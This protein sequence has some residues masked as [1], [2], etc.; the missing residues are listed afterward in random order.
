MSRTQISILIISLFTI[1]NQSAQENR[2]KTSFLFGK[3]I[4]TGSAININ[5][6]IS[7]T[8]SI[9]YGFD[10]GTDKRVDIQKTGFT[11]S[12]SSV[13]FSLKAAEGNYRVKVIYDAMTFKEEEVFIKAESRRLMLQSTISTDQSKR[14]MSFMVNLRSPKLVDNKTIILKERELTHLNWDEKLTLEFFGGVPV[15]SISIQSVEKIPTLF[16]AGDSTVT[17]QDLE[18][19]ASWGQFVTAYLDDRIVVANYAYSGASLSS[20]KAS[21]RL[22]KIASLM[23]NGDYL[24][25]EFGHNDQKQ[26]GKGEGPWLNYTELLTQFVKTARDNGA[27]P[28]FITP[29]QRRFFTGNGKLKDTH[30]E[31]PKAMRKIATTLVVP[32][33][34]LTKISTVLFESW[35]DEL[36]KKAF[37]YYPAN[38]FIGQNEEL[39]DNTHFNGFGANEIALCVLQ[40]IKNQHLTIAKYIKSDVLGYDPKHPNTFSSWQVPVSNRFES[41]KPTGN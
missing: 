2:L 29:I 41:L 35:G 28:I 8:N 14:T 9:G 21:R 37:V 1:S 6:P 38:T 39:K 34:D 40:E 19:W 4:T 18:P 7:Y 22:E 25:I 36:S 13:Y 10:F 11:S 20:F 16:L 15:E 31:Y 23:K 33:I 17:D 5:E 30:G 27:I 26:D 24:L 12:D 32:I 3:E